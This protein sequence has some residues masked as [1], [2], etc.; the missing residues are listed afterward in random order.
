MF[1]MKRASTLSLEIQKP[2]RNSLKWSDFTEKASCKALSIGIVLV[3]LN[4]FC[5]VFAILS[6]SE[7]IF[8]ESGSTISPKAS[9]IIVGIIQLFGSY[10]S[11]I[12]VDRAGRKVSKKYILIKLLLSISY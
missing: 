4:Q 3:A 10:I 9:S 5:G 7:N 8:K 12:L 11:T 6:Y 1:T 2:T